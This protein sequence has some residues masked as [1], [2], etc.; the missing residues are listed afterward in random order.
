MVFPNV[1]FCAYIYNI[2]FFPKIGILKLFRISKD[3]SISLK[4]Q[5]DYFTQ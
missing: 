5:K 3:F 2:P 4:Y 1:F